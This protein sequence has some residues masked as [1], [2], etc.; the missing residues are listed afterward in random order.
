MVGSERKITLAKR[1]L[2]HVHIWIRLLVEKKL[3]TKKK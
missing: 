2:Y 1:D 3:L